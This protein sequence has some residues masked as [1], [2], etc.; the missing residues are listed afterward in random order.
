MAEGDGFDD[1]KLLEQAKLQAWTL[2]PA[3]IA[4]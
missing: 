1:S 4:E 2:K 3:I